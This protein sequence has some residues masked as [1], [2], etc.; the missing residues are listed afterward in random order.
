M[1]VR[2][3]LKHLKYLLLLLSLV[4]I[5]NFLFFIL[6]ILT[7]SAD[8]KQCM[9]V[10]VCR[11]VYRDDRDLSYNLISISIFFFLISLSNEISIQS[12]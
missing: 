11:T 12:N 2:D 10:C 5:L 4:F 8:K 3:H 1:R 6:L 7:L 9:C